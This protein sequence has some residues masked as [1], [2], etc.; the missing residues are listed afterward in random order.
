MLQLVKNPQEPDPR[1]ALIRVN[2]TIRIYLY[3]QEWF[4][5]ISL[6]TLTNI[7]LLAMGEKNLNKH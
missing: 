1:G 6:L 4:S 5:L 7:A 2:T 3:L